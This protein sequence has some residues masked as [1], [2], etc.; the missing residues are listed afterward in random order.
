MEDKK[1][2]KDKTAQSHISNDKSVISASSSAFVSPPHQNPPLESKSQPQMIEEK[3]Q[4]T[5]YLINDNCYSGE[6][7]TKAELSQEEDLCK[8]LKIIAEM[9]KMKESVAAIGR[10]RLVVDGSIEYKSAL[11]VLEEQNRELD[12]LYD[13]TMH[14]RVQLKQ[15]ECFIKDDLRSTKA[16]VSEISKSFDHSSS[17][18]EN[19][20]LSAFDLRRQEQLQQLHVYQ[21]LQEAE[22]EQFGEGSEDDKRKLKK[23]KES[24][25]KPPNPKPSSDQSTTLLSEGRGYIPTNAPRPVRVGCELAMRN[26]GKIGSTPLI[27]IKI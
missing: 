13:Y 11:K 14:H 4:H 25:K 19:C 3:P 12:I 24:V 8:K 16:T 1:K 23:M 18:F 21:E 15:F 20:Y 2:R 7:P 26:D 10:Q 9:R 27:R 17:K 22:N 5:P 6:V